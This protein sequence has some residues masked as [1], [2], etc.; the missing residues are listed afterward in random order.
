MRYLVLIFVFFSLQSKAQIIFEHSPIIMGEN[1]TTPSGYSMYVKKGIIAE[2]VTVAVADSPDW[3]DYVFDEK[4]PLRDLKDLEEFILKEKHL[5][6]IPSKTEIQ[7]IGNNLHQTDVKLLE[8]IEE[9]TLYI[10][11]LNKR[12]EELEG[13][14]RSE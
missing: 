14:G 5:P 1:V 2:K 3:A 10:I 11:Q 6:N 4:Y 9:L 13:R 8:K 7:E 12:I